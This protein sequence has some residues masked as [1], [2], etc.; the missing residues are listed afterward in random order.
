MRSATSASASASAST[1]ASATSSTTNSPGSPSTSAH[2]S[3]TKPDR[4]LLVSGTVKD[5][6]A[7]SG[8]TFESRGLRDLKGLGE[9]PLYAAAETDAG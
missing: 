8:I 1:Q 9:W 5:L 4:E 6:V 3:P 2:A 7:G